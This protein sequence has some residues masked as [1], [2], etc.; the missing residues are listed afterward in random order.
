MTFNV[1]WRTG[2][3][4]GFSEVGRRAAEAGIQ[5]RTGNVGVI[6]FSFHSEDIIQHL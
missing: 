6:R 1:R 3:F 5:L 4:V 2:A